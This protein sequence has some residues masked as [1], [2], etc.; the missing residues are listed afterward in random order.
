MEGLCSR[1]ARS[2]AGGRAHARPQ[3]GAERSSISPAVQLEQQRPRPDSWRRCRAAASSA[4]GAGRRARRGSPPSSP[5]LQS[6]PRLLLRCRLLLLTVPLWLSEPFCPAL[7]S[8]GSRRE[9]GP[10]GP[11]PSAGAGAEEGGERLSPGGRRRRSWVF[12]V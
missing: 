9:K 10:T 2:P 6:P 4:R 8:L 7:A 1:G 12:A 3:R 11:G 5:L